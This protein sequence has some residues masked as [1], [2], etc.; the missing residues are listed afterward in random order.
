M[1]KRRKWTALVLG[2]VLAVSGLRAPVQA[3]AGASLAGSGSTEKVLTFDCTPENNKG[4]LFHGSTGFLYGVSE[5]NVP[6]AN[7]LSGIAPKIMVQKAAEGKQHPSG[8]GYR[9]THYLTACGV[10]NIQ[11]YLQDYYLEWPYEYQGIDDYNQKVQKIVSEMVGGKS[12]EEIASYSFV[13]FNEPNSIWYYNRFDDMC[14]DWST[15]YATIKSIHPAIKVAG[16]NFSV[17]DDNAYKKFFD[18]CAKN[19]CLPEYITWHELSKNSLTSFQGH[20]KKVKEYV[21]TYYDG[22]G[23]EP[24]IFVNETVNFDDIGNPGALVNWISIF[25]EQDVYASLPYW[26]LANSMNELAADTNKPNGA[27][28]VYRWYAQMTGREAP[29]TLQS[30]SAPGPYARLYGLTSVDEK[31]DRIYTLFGGQAVG[32]RIELKNIRSTASFADADR[33]HVTIYRTKLTG[34]HGFADEIPV[35]FDGNMAFSGDDLIW[36]VPDAELT[37]AYFAVVTKADDTEPLSWSDYTGKWQKTYEAEN[38][39]LIG[40]A[41]SFDKLQGGDLV[42]SNRSEVGGLNSQNDG[43]LFQ[44]E[45]PKDGDYRLNIYYSSQAPQVNPLTLKYVAGGGQ[46]RAIGALCTHTLTVDDGSPQ[47]I[48]Y[49]S[50]V[51]WGYYNYKTVILH[52]AKGS[53][54]I[55]LMHKGENQNGK[56]LNSMLCVLLDKIDLTGLTGDE[57][58]VKLREEGIDDEGVFYVNA[59]EDG[60]Y[61][62]VVNAWDANSKKS[63]RLYKSRVNYAKDAKADSEV[64][65]DWMNVAEKLEPGQQSEGIYLTAGAN[66]CKLQGADAGIKEI[67]FTEDSALTETKA[68]EIE[69]EDCICSGTDPKDD[70]PYAFGSAA[71]PEVKENTYASGGKVVEGFR[72]GKDNKVIWKV[73]VP[74]EG[75]YR[76]SVFYSNN[77][78]APVMKT[79]SGDNYVHPYNTD[80]VERYL[81]ISTGEGTPQTVYFRN[82]FCWDTFKNVVIDI[83]LKKGE[84]RIVFSNDN[85]YKFSPVQ[86]DFAPRLDKFLLAPAETGF[87]SEKTDPKDETG[88]KGE[89]EDTTPTDNGKQQTTDTAKPASNTQKPA[90]STEKAA[91]QQKINLKKQKITYLKKK[92]KNGILI[93]WKKD[94]NSSGYRICISTNKKFKKAKYI[95]IRKNTI[96]KKWI[97]KLKRGKKYYIK[98]CSF[99]TVGKTRQY[100]KYSKKRSIRL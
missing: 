27:W 80:L 41:Q 95:W 69:A 55:K 88:S 31:K 14:K 18:Y 93:K 89:T 98:I 16:P 19:N 61:R 2:M 52:L 51:K 33:A 58:S 5:V 30:A 39:K 26:G 25:E 13:I 87:L 56:E 85:S 6:S 66:R 90:V 38:A 42:R 99:V 7:L 75:N 50:T 84:N 46:N 92:K 32:Q 73:N 72:G 12:D 35:V 40:N 45:V 34:H 74:E 3:Q 70:Y 21:K 24:E 62:A 4:E 96:T 9:L 23:F 1:R 48:T 94:K 79:Q 28:W 77:E 11:I 83:R 91:A 43:V 65:I 100:G 20:C 49:D 44:V 15:I 82:T 67:V 81:Q 60:F 22:A 54:Q 47:D 97:K 29:L 8:D 10:E 86:D 59:P 57:T 63:F 76:L 17:Y 37:D 53:H 36:S 78:P 68:W 71:V 64:T